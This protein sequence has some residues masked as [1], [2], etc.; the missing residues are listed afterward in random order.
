VLTLGL[1][2]PRSSNIAAALNALR[3]LRPDPLLTQVELLES[4]GN[5]FYH[6][7]ILSLKYTLGSR[8]RVRAVYTVSKLIDEGTTNTASPQ[9]LLDR[10]AERALSL[11]DQRHRITFSGLFQVPYINLDLAP[12]VSFGSS[13]PFNIGAGFDRNLNDIENDRPNFITQIGRPVWRRPG[14]PPADDVKSALELSPIGSTGNLPRNYGVGP[15]T[16]TISLRASRTIVVREGLRVRPS[17]DVFNVF[18]NP[19]FSF[20]SEFV[21]RDDSDFLLPRRTQRPRSVL[22]SVKVSF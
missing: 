12:I 20:G 7:G 5:S 21:D 22:L 2:A 13:K 1:N 16:R 8:V 4:T 18:N 3:S 15:G 11:Q 6:G 14:S 19:I 10:R 17:I 9:D